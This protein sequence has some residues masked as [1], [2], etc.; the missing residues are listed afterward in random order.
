MGH[1]AAPE[2]TSSK[3]QG[4]E[5]RDTWQRQSSP[6]Q[7]GEVRGRGTHGGTGVHL[8][9]EVWSESITYVEACGCTPCTC[10]DLELVCG[11]LGLQGTDRGP[12]AHLRRGYEP[13]GG[14]KTLGPREVPELE[15]RERPPSTLRNVDGGTP[16]G[17]V[18]ISGN[19]H[20]QS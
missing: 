16:G 11:V 3:R 14:A 2:L 18:G 1:V 13:A 20:H 7:G 8:C 15:V 17:A 9:R 6:Q 19:G 4:P 10:L 12:R 5:P